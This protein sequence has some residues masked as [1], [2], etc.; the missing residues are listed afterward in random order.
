[1]VVFGALAA[2]EKAAV[3]DQLTALLPSWVPDFPAE[4]A[5]GVRDALRRA[6]IT[7]PNHGSKRRSRARP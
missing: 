1:M 3:L 7:P 4:G 5:D 6:R 2:E